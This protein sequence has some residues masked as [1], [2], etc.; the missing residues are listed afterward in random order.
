MNSFECVTESS[1][2]TKVS[3][4]FFIWMTEKHDVH[5]PL[6]DGQRKAMGTVAQCVEYELPT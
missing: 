5:L 6:S 2:L 1:I 4:V 3:G